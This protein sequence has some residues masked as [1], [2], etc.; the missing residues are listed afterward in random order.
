[1]RQRESEPTEPVEKHGYGLPGKIP[2]LLVCSHC[3]KSHANSTLNAWE[4]ITDE[5]ARLMI[6]RNVELWIP[7]TPRGDAATW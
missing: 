2:T 3:K 1:M 7:I 4:L 5:L 6:L